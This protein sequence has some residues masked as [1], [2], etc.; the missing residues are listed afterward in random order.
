MVNS[1]EFACI[2][3]AGGRG[4]RMASAGRHK[5]CFPIAGRPA[6]LR[7]MDAYAAAGLKRF[8]VVV[9]QMAEQVMDTVASEHPE[10]MFVF[11]PIPR[12][13][14]HAVC[15]AA[16]AL[17]AQGYT[18]PTVVVMGDKIIQPHIIM[19]LLE[20]YRRSRADAV[21]TVL[22]RA[23]DSTAGRVV[24]DRLGRFAGI[25]EK[26]D[27]DEHLRTGRRIR[28]GN[29][30]LDA[31]R[32]EQ[33]APSVN[34]SLYCVRLDRLREALRRLSGDNSQGELY[35][36]DAMG[37]IAQSHPVQTMPVEDP[38][39]LMAFNTPAELVAVEQALLARQKPPRVSPVLAK[40]AAR[41]LKPARR[42]LELIEAQPRAWRSFLREVY[43]DDAALQRRRQRAFVSVLKGFARHYGPDRPVLVVRAPGRINLMGRHI[44]HRGG[45]V[46]VMAIS[47]EALL[48]AAPR[49]DDLVRLRNA[50]ED[51]PPR[52]FTLAQLL[53]GYSWSDW[54]D[55][56]Q[57]QAAQAV[58]QAAPGDW[59]HYA[60][61]PLLRLQHECPQARLRGMDCF[62][63]G[64]V[65]MGSGLSSSSALVVAFAQAAVRLNGLHVSS[66]DF[67]D[68]CGEGEWFVGSRGGSADH[69]AICRAQAGRVA[70]IG[71]FPFGLQ[72]Q[73]SFP[74]DLSLVVAYSGQR[75]LK[76]DSARDAFNQRVAC[77][78]LAQM[79]LRK[80]WPPAASAEHL[81]DLTPDRLNLG[82]DEL[83]R[84]LSRLPER[85]TRPQ[86]RTMF[87]DQQA[88]LERIFSTHR[89]RGGY[90][91]RGVAMFGLS[92]IVRA[93]QYG[94]LLSRGELAGLGRYMHASHDGDRVSLRRG[95]QV[96][97]WRTRLDEKVLGQLA[98][99]QADLAQQCG[100]Y[101][102]STEAVDALVDLSSQVEGV[103]GAQLAGAGL[104]GS[105]MVLVR[106]EAVDRLM[107]HLRKDFYEP[108]GLDFGARIMTPVAGAGILAP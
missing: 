2:I 39:D 17:A 11:Q 24:A 98:A 69:A 104:G 9:G 51:H 29:R 96:R 93:Q 73:V 40:P 45:M 81:R 105:M 21:V 59:S 18:G 68:L 63:S 13:T 101:A 61:A 42:W 10:T 70:R 80:H 67:I 38:A 77:Y 36:T 103:I 79:H 66:T 32:L 35:L 74:S 7:A 95:G 53:R 76:S 28:L 25:V 108:R 57:S 52:Q 97:A 64:D 90:D 4:K 46:N 82:V 48:A 6:I 37:L 84:A 106:R 19:Q 41:L 3:L 50:R 34:A 30:L 5:A 8:V 100:R 58:L 87:P 92:E 22:P 60:R 91:L 71:F 55:V 75:A 62:V 94:R 23:A 88:A 78:E 15:V 89:H 31:A 99:Q 12:G 56:I 49:E 47:C 85:A 26:S 107:H 65:P 86:L 1:E 72:G 44:D 83:Y 102:C 54:M 43:G 16:E 20:E 33:E 14:G 27:I